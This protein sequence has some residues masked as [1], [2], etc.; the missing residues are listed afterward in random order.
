MDKH[1]L[2]LERSEQV[3]GE[4]MY[5]IFDYANFWPAYRRQWPCFWISS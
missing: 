1:V 2:V 3:R 5:P 4:R